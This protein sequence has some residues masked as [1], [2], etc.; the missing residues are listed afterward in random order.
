MFINI[1]YIFTLLQNTTSISI[2]KLISYLPI[3][4]N[5]TYNNKQK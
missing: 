2:L 1:L 5:D 3:L 4:D